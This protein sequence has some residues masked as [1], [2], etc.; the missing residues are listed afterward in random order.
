M[1]DKSDEILPE[2]IERKKESDIYLSIYTSIREKIS[3]ISLSKPSFRQNRHRIHVGLSVD[4]SLHEAAKFIAS[5]FKTDVSELYAQGLLR[6]LEEKATQLPENIA[7]NVT[8]TFPKAPNQPMYDLQVS[9]MKDDL[10]SYLERFKKFESDRREDPNFAKRNLYMEK[11]TKTLPKALR[12]AH[13]SEDAEF[14]QL[15]YDVAEIVRTKQKTRV[16]AEP[17]RDGRR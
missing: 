17:I 5:F 15:L 6:V 12:L 4:E 7:L 1:S 11:L 9:L 13:H 14:K 16:L 2:G 10:S 8:H 3:E